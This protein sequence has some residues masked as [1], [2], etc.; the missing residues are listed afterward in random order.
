M[1]FKVMFRKSSV[2]KIYTI[3]RN[4]GPVAKNAT[5]RPSGWDYNLR[6]QDY[7]TSALPH[8]LHKPFVPTTWAR[9]QY[10]YIYI[11]EMVMPVKYMGILKIIFGIYTLIMYILTTH[12]KKVHSNF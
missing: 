7:K 1:K 8:V 3:R 4:P 12:S 9:V 11:N 2:V 6:P 10:I 5:P